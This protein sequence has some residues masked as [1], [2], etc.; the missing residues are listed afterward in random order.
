M[1][2]W[3]PATKAL[4]A[5]VPAVTRAAMGRL[6]AASQRLCSELKNERDLQAQ[7]MVVLQQSE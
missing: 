2:G 3:G 1:A 6:E 5:A 7:M 4:T